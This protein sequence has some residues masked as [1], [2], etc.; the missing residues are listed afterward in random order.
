MNVFILHQSL[1]GKESY[2]HTPPDSLCIIS[3]LLYLGQRVNA[4][5]PGFRG[6]ETSSRIPFQSEVISRG[7]EWPADLTVPLLHV[8]KSAFSQLR[9]SGNF[10]LGC[11]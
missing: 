7:T 6:P 9:F 3:R 10:L 1:T 5:V 4:C 8:L 11:G 2:M